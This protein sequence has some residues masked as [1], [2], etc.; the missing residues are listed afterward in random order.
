[1]LAHLLAVFFLLF[2]HDS[3]FQFKFS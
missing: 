1:L 3:F 2:S